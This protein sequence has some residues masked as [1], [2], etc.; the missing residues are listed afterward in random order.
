MLKKSGERDPTIKGFS[1]SGPD[2][3]VAVVPRVALQPNDEI[4]GSAEVLKSCLAQ[5]S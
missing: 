4:A 5:N 1:A 3:A 2:V